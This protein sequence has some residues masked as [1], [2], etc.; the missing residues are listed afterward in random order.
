VLFCKIVKFGFCELRNQ[1]PVVGSP[2]GV[3][4]TWG[5]PSVIS[6]VAAL[7]AWVMI[8]DVSVVA[9]AAT[10]AIT[11]LKFCAVAAVGAAAGLK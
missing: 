9:D 7:N 2:W 5:Y 11:E 8:A 4:I 1:L 6:D 3:R 10:V